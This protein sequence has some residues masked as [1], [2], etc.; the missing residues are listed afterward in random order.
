MIE[1]R[2]VTVQRL[3]HLSQPDFRLLAGDLALNDF[4][5]LDYVSKQNMKLG[6]CFGL[7]LAVFHNICELGHDL[8]GNIL[9]VVRRECICMSRIQ[10][11]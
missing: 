6:V 7:K 3:S 11:R 10:T 2:T 9:I 1:V 5:A 4:H 8:I